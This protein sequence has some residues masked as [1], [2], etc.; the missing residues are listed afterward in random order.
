MLSACHA[1]SLG[2]TCTLSSKTNK[3]SPATGAVDQTV[4]VFPFPSC[5]GGIKNWVGD[6]IWQMIALPVTARNS[7][8]LSLIA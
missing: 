5:S 8:D 1:S 6:V 2:P 3:E 4:S 7:T